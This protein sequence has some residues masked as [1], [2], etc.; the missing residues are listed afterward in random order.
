MEHKSILVLPTCNSSSQAFKQ[1][2]KVGQAQ[3]TRGVGRDGEVTL[4]P[5]F[6]LLCFSFCAATHY[7]SRLQNSPYFLRIQ[8]RAS[9]WNEAENRERDWGEAKNTLF[10]RARGSRA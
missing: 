9:M 8:V 4:S 7:L 1:G 10:S 3:N 2:R 6:F 5:F